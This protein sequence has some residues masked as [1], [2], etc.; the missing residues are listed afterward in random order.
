MPARLAAAAAARAPPRRPPRGRHGASSS[1][2]PLGV[3]GERVVERGPDPPASPRRRAAGRAARAS[4]SAAYGPGEGVGDEQA[5]VGQRLELRD[6]VV[7]PP[8]R[9]DEHPRP[10][11]Q[12]PVVARGSIPAKRTPRATPEAPASPARQ[13]ASSRPADHELL[14]LAPR[15]LPGGEHA[16]E[17]L[18]L[19]VRAVGDRGDV[20]L[21][22]AGPEGS[23]GT[24]HDDRVRVRRAAPR[25]AR[26]R[27]TAR[28]AARRATGGARPGA[29]RSRGGPGGCRRPGRRSGSRP[30][31]GPAGP[32][33]SR[34]RGP[35]AGGA[36]SIA[37]RPRRRAR[38]APRRARCSAYVRHSRAPRGGA[39]PRPTRPRAR[40]EPASS[41]SASRSPAVPPSETSRTSTARHGCARNVPPKPGVRTSWIGCS[42]DVL[43]T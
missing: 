42:G 29:A 17:A 23:T 20:A 9:A 39:R 26:P 7:L 28:A 31:A 16:V 4:G 27:S 3:A 19:R 2:G 18:L 1:R 41:S 32:R 36:P 14:A 13:P 30:G 10:P 12:R 21:A 6:P 5:A 11:Q 25:P 15:R 38:D 8:R 37:A 34:S 24:G 22:R 40:S 43:S 33:W 35:R